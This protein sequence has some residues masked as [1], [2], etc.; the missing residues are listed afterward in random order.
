[1][2][3]EWLRHH[4]DVQIVYGNEPRDLSLTEFETLELQETG[5]SGADYATEQQST[6][7]VNVSQSATTSQPCRQLPAS[8]RSSLRERLVKEGCVP[9]KDG[10]TAGVSKATLSEA[11]QAKTKIISHLPTTVK[12]HQT[13]PEESQVQVQ[14]D[15][16]SEPYPR[17]DPR[18]IMHRRFSTPPG[19]PHRIQRRPPR[20]LKKSTQPIFDEIPA[21]TSAPR[22]HV[23]QER[24]WRAVAG[25]LVDLKKLSA[26]QFILLSIIAAHGA[27][28][29]QQ[30]ELVRVSGQDKRSVPHRT[31]ELAKA[32]YIEKTPIVSDPAYCVSRSELITVC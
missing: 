16:S 26:M 27:D 29:I 7:Q 3:W 24:T 10:A 4:R 25:H 8:I 1:M 22:M 20:G 19:T 14:R 18:P 15:Q 23:S 21:S 9:N 32:G 31:D 5:T 17:P 2:I 12:T 28:G 30:P 6:P 11:S 13:A